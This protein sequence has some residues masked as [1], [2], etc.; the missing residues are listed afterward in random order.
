MGNII[1]FPVPA[2]DPGRCPLI[3]LSI[4]SSGPNHFGGHLAD[5]SLFLPLLAMFSS[6]RILHQQE[7]S[8]ARFQ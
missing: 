3:F 6:L 2:P 5:A 4:V 7:H 8:G 1:I